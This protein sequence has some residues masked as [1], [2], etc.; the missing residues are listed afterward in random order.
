V[1]GP[2]GAREQAQRRGRECDDMRLTGIEIKV[3][4][5]LHRR[6]KYGGAHTPVET[7]VKGFRKDLVGDARDAVDRLIRERILLSKPTRYGLEVS[8]NPEQ[9]AFIHRVCDWF[10]QNVDTFQERGSHDFP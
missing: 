6:G 4:W 3:I 1:E 2:V 10:E 9:V 8:L 5:R 7:A